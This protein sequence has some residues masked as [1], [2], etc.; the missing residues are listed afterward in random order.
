MAAKKSAKKKKVSVEVDPE[1]LHALL[2]AAAA[3]SEVA[4]GVIQW[5]DDPA[6]RSK[7]TKKAAKKRR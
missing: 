5:I 3:L 6:V 7:L 2:D 1:T 4:H